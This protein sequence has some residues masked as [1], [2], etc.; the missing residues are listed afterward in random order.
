MQVPF[1]SQGPNNSMSWSTKTIDLHFTKGLIPGPISG[2]FAATD[3]AEFVL[4]SGD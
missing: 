1:G 3:L 4:P 2:A